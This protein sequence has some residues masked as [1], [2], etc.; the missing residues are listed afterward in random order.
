MNIS[1]QPLENFEVWNSFLKGNRPHTFLHTWQW[2]DFQKELGASLWRVG[3][4]DGEALCGIMLITKVQARRGTFLFCPHGPVLEPGIDNQKLERIIQETVRYLKQIANEEKCSFIRISSLFGDTIE[5]KKI[6]SD[7][8]FRGAPIHMHPERA[9]ILDLTPDEQ[10]LLANMRKT[11]RYSIKKAAQEGVTVRMTN[12][13][14]DLEAFYDI[15]LQ[16]VRRQNF[17][18]F[19]RSYV[20]KELACFQGEQSAQFLFAEYQGETLATAFVVFTPWS[21]FYHHGAATLRYPK[22]PASYLL[23]WEI[24]REAK[25]RG[26]SYYN[27]WGLAHEGRHTIVDRLAQKLR[28]SHPW[29]GITLFKTGF[30]GFEQNY[31]PAQDYIL[32]SRYWINYVIEYGR[33][34]KR[35]L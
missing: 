14:K 32:S 25:R 2:G 34:L 9:W 13:A 33:R 7:Y 17:T 10:A 4:F 12:D 22:L 29:E 15:Y 31:L 26:C 28:R 5:V 1:I 18:P 27:F 3:I 8:G 21:A 16:T 23:Q 20:E 30:G 35:G 11:T 19:S 24:I 6:F